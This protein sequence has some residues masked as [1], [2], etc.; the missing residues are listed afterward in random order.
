MGS[1]KSK[2]EKM[3]KKNKFKLL[4]FPIPNPF[5]NPVLE[6]ASILLFSTILTRNILP[7]S[8]QDPKNLLT[9]NLQSPPSEY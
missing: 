3:K 9:D 1:R 4:F 6:Q 7:E 5:P 8:A 2:K